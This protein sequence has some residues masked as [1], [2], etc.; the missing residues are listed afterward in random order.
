MTSSEETLRRMLWLMHGCPINALYG[1]DGEMSCSKCAIDFKRDPV[2][3]IEN[4]LRALAE[5]QLQ[6]HIDGQVKATLE[7][8][9]VQEIL[10]LI[11]QL[12]PKLLDGSS[13]H[14]EV[15]MN[16]AMGVVPSKDDVLENI[17]LGQEIEKFKGIIA[18]LRWLLKQQDDPF[19]LSF[20]DAMLDEKYEVNDEGNS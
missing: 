14:A 9:S 11:E 3:T 10:E 16:A 18:V 15:A 12:K 8:R 6:K 2:P 20:F 5:K 4:K 7:L 17:F 19:D 13:K 1:D